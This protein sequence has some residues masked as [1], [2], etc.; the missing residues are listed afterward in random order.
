MFSHNFAM[1][2][3]GAGCGSSANH[4]GG[5]KRWREFRIAFKSVDL[6]HGLVTNAGFVCLRTE[7]FLRAVM[8]HEAKTLLMGSS[9]ATAGS[10]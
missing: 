5:L 4:S 2:G 10:E 6:F 9:P 7:S 3:P 8:F 1:R